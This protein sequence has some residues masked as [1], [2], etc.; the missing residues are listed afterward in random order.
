MW[1]AFAAALV[2]ILG[3]FILGLVAS[4]VLAVR[5]GNIF[6][7]LAIIVISGI[8]LRV[9]GM[10]VDKEG[11]VFSLLNILAWLCTFVL[12]AIGALVLLPFGVI[13]SIAAIAFIGLTARVVQEPSL[14]WSAIF[15]SESI[16]TL[17]FLLDGYM[18]RRRVGLPFRWATMRL[19]GYSLLL[20]SKSHERDLVQL[21]KDRP[22]LPVSL[23]L[24]EDFDALVVHSSDH[25]DWTIIVTD[26]LGRNGIEYEYGDPS[27][28]RLVLA[29]PLICSD[30]GQSLDEYRSLQDSELLDHLLD[31]HLTGVTLFPDVTGTIAVAP[32]DAVSGY[33]V[34]PLTAT[35]ARQLL[36]R[37]D[38]R[39]IPV[40]VNNA[41]NSI[42][43][44]EN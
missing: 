38:E 6:P 37:R 44:I 12:M 43:Q 13:L 42:G 41:G 16:S 24:L 7:L 23:T 2:L 3:K 5:V 19:E 26:I 4:V 28:L 20:I 35:V 22:K 29:L 34:S 18:H 36:V 14:S 31:E 21:M 10:V 30:L 1:L 39:M 17:I 9:S 33:N 40:E 11:P 8:L 15:H 32:S 27:L 25:T